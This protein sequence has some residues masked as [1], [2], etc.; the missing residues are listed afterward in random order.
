M[1][2][3]VIN[4]KL[5]I[6]LRDRVALALVFILPVIFFAIFA[7]IFG[8]GMGGG[9]APRIVAI[10]VDE[11]QTERSRALVASL[12]DSGAGMRISETHST[13]DGPSIPWTSEQARETVRDGKA[14]AAIIIPKGFKIDFSGQSKTPILVLVDP[15][16]PIA[17]T[18]IP[19]MIQGAAMQGNRFTMIETGMAEFE[20]YGGALTPQQQAAIKNWEA[21]MAADQAADKQTDT[22]TDGSG[23]SKVDAALV[24]VTVEDVQKQQ[25]GEKRSMVAYY[26]AGIGVMFLLF[27]VAGAS[28][29]LLEDQEA[30]ILERMISS[31]LG[32]TRLLMANWIWISIMGMVS[33]FTLYLFATFVFGLGPWTSARIVSCIVITL[34]TAAAASALGLLLAT[35]CRT[36]GQLA[37]ISTVIILVMSALGGSMMPRFVMPEIVRE[38]SWWVTFNAWSVEG[39]L[40]VFW[41][42]SATTTLGEMLGSMAAPLGVLAGMTVVFMVIARL[43]A[44][45]WE[46]I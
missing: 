38:I 26:A 42:S 28:G 16:N 10:V 33:M 2:V 17:G 46:R 11:D 37:G 29:S 12:K 7:G 5:K 27:S 36:R 1:I 43:L 35:A 45:R 14:D 19:G 3:A 8:G 30:G 18:M 41:Y 40:E 20:K 4:A 6:L 9:Q 32:M 13:N 34:F 44:R 31:P 39:Y 15:S 22:T 25:S 21:E 24:P 23:Q